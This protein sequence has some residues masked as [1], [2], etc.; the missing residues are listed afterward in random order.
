MGGGV[1]VSKERSGVCKKWVFW[2]IDVLVG[3]RGQVDKERPYPTA[4]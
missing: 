2:V 3:T 4:T 1:T